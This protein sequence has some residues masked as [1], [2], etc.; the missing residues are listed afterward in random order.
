MHD[1]DT[2]E[3]RSDARHCGTCEGF[4]ELLYGV[5]LALEG[6]ERGLRAVRYSGAPEMVVRPR[7]PFRLLGAPD[8]CV[9]SNALY[10]AVHARNQPDWEAG[11]KI[12]VTTDD[13]GNSMMLEGDDYEIVALI[14]A[15]ACKQLRTDTHEPAA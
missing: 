8:I 6:G 1:P 13:S 12:F 11:R 4:G 3:L 7:L 2:Y 9:Q 15:H 14:E 10:G 5:Q